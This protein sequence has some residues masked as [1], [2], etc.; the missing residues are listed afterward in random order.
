MYFGLFEHNGFLIY[1]YMQNIVPFKNI[2]CAFDSIFTSSGTYFGIY[3]L[4]IYCIERIIF[5]IAN[6]CILSVTL[7]FKKVLKL[8]FHLFLSVI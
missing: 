8:F 7:Y 2:P 3:I 1:I 5:C 6:V 4:E